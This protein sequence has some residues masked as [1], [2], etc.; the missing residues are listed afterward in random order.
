[1]T[2]NKELYEGMY[3][4]SATLSEDAR[5]KALEKITSG[6]AQTGGTIHKIHDQGRKKMA[7]E[8]RG[9]REG[10]YYLLYFTATKTA[11][12]DLWREYH[13]NEDL[14]RFLM[15]KT[16]EVKQELAFKQLPE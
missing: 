15:L 11:L 9:M 2:D 14:L 1:M 12:A 5:S 4:L 16:D 6:I 7:Y 3:I 13:L 10:H 8:I